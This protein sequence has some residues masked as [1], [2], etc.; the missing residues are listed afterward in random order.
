MLSQKT[1]YALQALAYL[2][3]RHGE[4]APQV[5]RTLAAVLRGGELGEDGSRGSGSGPLSRRLV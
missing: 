1:K 4:E 5:F 2:A 3:A